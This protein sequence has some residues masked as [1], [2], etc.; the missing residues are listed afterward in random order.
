MVTDQAAWGRPRAARPRSAPMVRTTRAIFQLWFG[1][2]PPLFAVHQCGLIGC[3]LVKTRH[4]GL[5]ATFWISV[6][7][8]F[9]IFRRK[10]VA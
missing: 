4:Q 2:E 7:G 8:L 1:M 5:I 6:G 3:N 10:I 9:A